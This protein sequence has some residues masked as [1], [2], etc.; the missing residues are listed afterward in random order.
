[1]KE[2]FYGIEEIQKQSSQ[3]L[4]PQEEIMMVTSMEELDIA[5]LITGSQHKIKEIDL[6][7]MENT[8]AEI[9]ETLS[10]EDMM[11]EEDRFWNMNE[12]T[13][14]NDK[15]K[16]ELRSSDYEQLREK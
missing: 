8:E 14:W 12:I 11:Y 1:M 13:N 7:E 10:I 2:D 15:F 4:H 3:D 9:N 5:N 16:I 6:K